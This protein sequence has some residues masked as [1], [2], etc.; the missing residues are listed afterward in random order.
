[1]KG[2]PKVWESRQPYN[3]TPKAFVPA[4]RLYRRQE[5]LPKSAQAFVEWETGVGCERWRSRFDVSARI[6]INRHNCGPARPSRKMPF[7]KF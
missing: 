1:M 5:P 3:Y 6:A 7:G 4:V 2:K